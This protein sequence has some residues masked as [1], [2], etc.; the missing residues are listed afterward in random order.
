MTDFFISYNKAD[1]A[2]AEWIAWVL[3]EHG[4][5]VIIQAWDFRPGGNFILDMQRATAEA[6]R[7]ILVLSDAY[8][9]GLYTQPEWAA[10]FKPDP[11]STARK[12]LPIRVAPCNP[13]GMLA[14]LVYV[15]LV[16][17][18]ETEAETLL[19]EALPDR[20]K[21]TSRPRFPQG[22]TPAVD[23]VTPPTV[24][25]PTPAA[26]NLQ[27]VSGGTGTQVNNPTA[28]VFAGPISG[29]TIN[30]TYPQ[31]TPPPP[32]TPPPTT[33][34]RLALFQKLTRLPSPQFE[35]ILFALDP[36]A[37]NVP[38]AQAPQADRVKAL[39]DWATRLGPGLESV[40]AVYNQ[41]V[42]PP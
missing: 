26:P 21:P 6:Q 24:A 29:G 32:T 23:R 9:N 34:Q 38:S 12:L 42:S 22:E 11:T 36:P 31:G 3:E 28:P 33:T 37:G 4:Y 16:G 13:T 1:K 8:L 15:D 2:W 14:A 10:A 35:Q 7:T 27:T 19:L 17:K 25:Y 5:T 20:A 41:V 40:E 39:L 18:S 30:I